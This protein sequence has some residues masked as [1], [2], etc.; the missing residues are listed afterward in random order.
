MIRYSYLA[1]NGCTTER[2]EF[3]L[4]SEVCGSDTLIIARGV[5]MMC[6]IDIG[7]IDEMYRAAMGR[8]R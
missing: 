4:G 2:L 3:G 7:P 5:L 6:E 8:K 1:H